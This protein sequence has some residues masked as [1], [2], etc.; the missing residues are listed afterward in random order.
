LPR[1][2]AYCL[3]YSRR[4]VS[5]LQILIDLLFLQVRFAHKRIPGLHAT[6]LGDAP[7]GRRSLLAFSEWTPSA[8]AKRL[9]RT[10]GGRKPPRTTRERC[11]RSAAVVG[12]ACKS[13][14]SRFRS[15]QSLPSCLYGPKPAAQQGGGS[16][17]WW[18][19][20]AP[21]PVAETSVRK[22]TPLLVFVPRFG[23][24]NC[25]LNSWSQGRCFSF[26]RDSETV[27]AG[28]LGRSES[29]RQA[30]DACLPLFQQRQG[31]TAE[32]EEASLAKTNEIGVD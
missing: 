12:D 7:D 32:W 24:A 5:L 20:V 21:F 4:P 3:S 23:S 2:Y 27:P 13:R 17:T 11:L 18:Q 19:R 22:V 14:S 9:G 10:R 15:S 28:T 29:Q 8:S 25:V 16:E 31:H 26:A 6:V 1:P 30:I